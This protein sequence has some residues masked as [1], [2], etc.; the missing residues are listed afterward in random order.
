MIGHAGLGGQ[1]VRYDVDNELSLGYLSNGL[2]NGFGNSAR[3]YVPLKDA[4][5][6]SVM[7]LREKQ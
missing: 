4:I 2:K 6:D 5:Y 7:K 1:N 3:T